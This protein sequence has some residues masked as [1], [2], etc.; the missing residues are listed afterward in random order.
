MIFLRQLIYLHILLSSQYFIHYNPSYQPSKAS[1]PL[2]IFKNTS[3]HQ[4]CTAPITVRMA[5]NS[6]VALIALPSKST[7]SLSSLLLY[8][9]LSLLTPEKIDVVAAGL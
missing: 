5:I 9:K 8:S 7:S 1:H 6:K 2:S 4:Q 3:N